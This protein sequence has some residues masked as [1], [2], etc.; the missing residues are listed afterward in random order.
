MWRAGENQPETKNQVGFSPTTIAHDPAHRCLKQTELSPIS[1]LSSPL[2]SSTI[3]TCNERMHPLAHLQRGRNL[4]LE[5]NS[6]KGRRIAVLAADGFEKVELS[7]PVTALRVA[8]AEVDIVSLHRG[9]IRGVNLHE[10]AGKVRV[11]KTLAEANPADYDGLL[12]P[13]GFINPDLLRQSSAARNFVRAFDEQRKPIATLCHGP[14]VLVSAG[15]VQGRV[16]TS[17]PGIRDDMVNAGATWLDR[18]VV[19]DGNLVSSRGPQD[20]VPFVRAMRELFMES[21]PIAAAAPPHLQSDPQRDAPPSLV[22]NALRWLPRPSLRTAVG[23]A[24]LGAGLV[25]AS[26]R[27]LTAS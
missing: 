8:G 16:M 1:A 17:W 15:V 13:G 5:I 27:R 6:L 19:R 9:R 26:R 24:V 20:M 12:L 18:E 14:W 23:L 3:Y 25:A 21:G 22:V 4:M 10:P 2:R 7:V 11:T